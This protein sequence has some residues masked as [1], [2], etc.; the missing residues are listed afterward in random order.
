[1][2]MSWAVIDDTYLGR[3]RRFRLHYPVGKGLHLLT[4]RGP[5]GDRMDG[6]RLVRPWGDRAP[7]GNAIPGV[8]RAGTVMGRL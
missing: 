6:S 8:G 1:M 5:P 4:R 2:A 3:D 7:A